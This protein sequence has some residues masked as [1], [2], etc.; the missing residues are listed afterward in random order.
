MVKEIL[1]VYSKM[2]SRSL[3]GQLSIISVEVSDL[4]LSM[5]CLCYFVRSWT[6]SVLTSIDGHLVTAN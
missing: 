2:H 3:S 4:K 1:S 6:A 5:I